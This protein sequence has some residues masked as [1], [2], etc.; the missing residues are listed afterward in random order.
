MSRSYSDKAF[1]HRLLYDTGKNAQRGDDVKVVR[2]NTLERLDARNIDRKVG[3]D[4]GVFSTII[5]DAAKTASHFLGAP[6]EWVESK[7]GLLIREQR[8]I[9]YPETRTKE[10]LSAA[11]ARMD[12]L[13]KDRHANEQKANASKS[14]S[15][16]LSETDRARAVKIAVQSF[17][18]AFQ[19][20]DSVHYT[21]GPSRF[22]GIRNRLRYADGEYP[23][24]EDCS[25]MFTW[26]TW[27]GV[28]SVAGMSAPDHVNGAGWAAGYTGTLLT[29]GWAVPYSERRGGDAVIYGSGFPGHHVAMIDNENHDMV[30]SHGSEAGPFHLNWRYRHDVMQIRRYI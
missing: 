10:M 11:E 30:Y 24:Y 13:L 21:Q 25:S 2:R 9:V 20:A 29:H 28:T 3:P 23:T 22:M 7:S 18:L 19:H 5:L 6:D 15:W 14:G 16:D 4:D 8:I 17:R 27:N 12:R 1:P 26:A